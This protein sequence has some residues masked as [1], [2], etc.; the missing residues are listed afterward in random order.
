MNRRF[1]RNGQDFVVRRRAAAFLCTRL[2]AAP[3]RRA[4]YRDLKKRRRAAAL[5]KSRA[6]RTIRVFTHSDFFLK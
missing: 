2:R 1:L 3:K 6:S 4:T 5:S